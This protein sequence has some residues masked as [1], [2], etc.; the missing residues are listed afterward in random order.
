MSPSQGQMNQTRKTRGWLV[1][2]FNRRERNY[3]LCMNV[4][5]G[6]FRG[7]DRLC[8]DASDSP[9]EV[10]RTLRPRWHLLAK[11]GA[12]ELSRGQ[13]GLVC[14]L[15]SFP[16]LSRQILSSWGVSE[17]SPARMYQYKYVIPI[18]PDVKYAFARRGAFAPR[19]FV[20]ENRAS[21]IAFEFSI[22]RLPRCVHS[23]SCDSIFA[24]VVV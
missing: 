8:Y 9:C 3:F 12:H 15:T 22:G 10:C 13:P 18:L 21:Y 4:W 23:V 24:C 11:P 1:S 20:L 2:C 14:A 19:F 6:P 7:S 16:R 17:I 5:P